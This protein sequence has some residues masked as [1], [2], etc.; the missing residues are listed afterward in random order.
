MP[1]VGHSWLLLLLLLL[2]VLIILGPVKLS[3][4]GGALGKSIRDFRKTASEAKDQASP[5]A[6]SEVKK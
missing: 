4:V 5:E 1:F 2:I 3:Q 6:P